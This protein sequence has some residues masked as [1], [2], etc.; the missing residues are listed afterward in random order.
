MLLMHWPDEQQPLGQL[1]GL[2]APPSQLEPLHAPQ[3][4]P[5]E[6]GLHAWPD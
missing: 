1:L 6:P 3:E 5:L 4:P 2:H